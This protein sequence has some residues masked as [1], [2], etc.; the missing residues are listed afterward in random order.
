MAEIILWNIFMK[1]LF[2]LSWQV[3]WSLIRW[4]NPDY[5][6]NDSL[7]RPDTKRNLIERTPFLCFPLLSALKAGNGV[8]Q[9]TANS[10]FLCRPLLCFCIYVTM[11]LCLPASVSTITTNLLWHVPNIVS[12]ATTI[13]SFKYFLLD[14]IILKYWRVWEW[15]S[16][17]DLVIGVLIDKL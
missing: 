13:F 8:P 7:F 9:T 12:L 15:C 1:Q 4:V 14:Q 3:L 11:N 17:A 6:D 2:S 5:T 16:G 10:D